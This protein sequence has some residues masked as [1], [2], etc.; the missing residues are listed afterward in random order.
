VNN[1][2]YFKYRA[3]SG[4]EI[5]SDKTYEGSK[6][7]AMHDLIM[8]YA[9]GV[10]PIVEIDGIRVKPLRLSEQDSIAFLNKKY[11]K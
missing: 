9:C 1:K 6:A 2:L 10:T 7:S 4:R 3:I 5:A 11:A 8:E